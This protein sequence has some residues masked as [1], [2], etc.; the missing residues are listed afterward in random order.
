VRNTREQFLG[1]AFNDALAAI[2]R[3]PDAAERVG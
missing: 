2:G 3:V 1:Q